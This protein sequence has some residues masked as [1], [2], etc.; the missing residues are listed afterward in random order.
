M[1][2][3]ETIGLQPA[4]DGGPHVFVESLEQP[5]LAADDEHHLRR[6]LRIRD[7]DPVTLSDA[8]GRWCAA[9]FGS[10][11]EPYSDTIFVPRPDPLITV[12]FVVPKGDR[13]SWI[14][15]KLTEL[16]VDRIL[17]LSSQRSVVRWDGERGEKHLE[18]LRS[19]ARAAA[20]QS[21]QVR[22]PRIEPMQPAAPVAAQRGVART[23][24]DGNPPTL[25]LP[26]LLVG[27]E[28]GWDPDEFG[29]DEARI[30]LGPSVLRSET[31]AITAGAVL[32]MLRSRLVREHS[33]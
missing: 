28:G 17:P 2:G 22:I 19:V 32:M 21:R 7:G 31:A 6:V 30:G 12:G 25:D 33:A 26:T 11:P 16:G 4:G 15:Q 10:Q 3:E 29:S 8:A 23:H 13:P 14:V 20:M 24:R 18:R 1:T 9:R 5:M 27:P